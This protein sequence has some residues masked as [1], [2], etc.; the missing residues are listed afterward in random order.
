[1]EKLLLVLKLGGF[2]LL[3][4]FVVAWFVVRLLWPRR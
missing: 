3:F 1:M 4:G 2:A